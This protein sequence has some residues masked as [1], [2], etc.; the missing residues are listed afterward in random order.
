MVWQQQNSKKN[1]PNNTKN[2]HIV[3]PTHPP[4]N[5]IPSKPPKNDLG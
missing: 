2:L 3:S 5:K 4:E 1:N